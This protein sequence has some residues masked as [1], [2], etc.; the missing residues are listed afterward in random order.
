[1]GWAIRTDR[2][3]L[4]E[5]RT[6]TGNVVDAVE[7]YD[8]ATDPGENVNLAA[9]PE[10]QPLVKQLSAQLAAGWKAALPK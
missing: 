10:F 2:Y 9:Q 7:L 5:W 3:R 8:H 4:I 6:N 1:M